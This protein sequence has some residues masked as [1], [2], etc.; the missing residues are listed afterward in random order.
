VKQTPPLKLDFIQKATVEIFK[1]HSESLKIK[2][3]QIARA[4]KMYLKVFINGIDTERK[5]R[6]LK[7]CY[8]PAT[9]ATFLAFFSCSGH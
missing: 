7:V 2:G 8:V 6:L 3:L 1:N 5:N 4:T 9:S